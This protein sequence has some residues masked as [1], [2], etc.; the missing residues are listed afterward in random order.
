MVVQEFDRPNSAYM[1]FYERAESLEPVP[2]T[3]SSGPQ[4]HDTNSSK[5]P[6]V[7]PE[8]DTEHRSRQAASAQSQQVHPDAVTDELMAP[9]S[10]Q[11]VQEPPA[12]P[13]TSP[14][15]SAQLASVSPLKV[16]S[17]HSP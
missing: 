12:A 9:A 11:A 16:R 13:A 17:F 1:L 5:Y 14:S 15:V 3:A 2:Q 7:Q 10:P 6:I 8:P 4:S